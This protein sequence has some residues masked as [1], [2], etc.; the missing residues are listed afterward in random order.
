MIKIRVQR[1]IDRVSV[2]ICD[3]AKD[4]DWIVTVTIDKTCVAGL[5]DDAIAEKASAIIAALCN[6]TVESDR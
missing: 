1:H 5:T 4:V 2:S 3:D 6:E